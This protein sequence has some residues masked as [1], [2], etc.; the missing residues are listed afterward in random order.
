MMKKFTPILFFLLASTAFSQKGYDIKINIKN[1][2]DTVAYLG[3][4]YWDK[5]YLL[6]TCKK[7]RKGVIEFKGKDDLEKGMYLLISQ[8]KSK[9][10]DFFVNDASS[11]TMN[12]N[13]D[14]VE[15][16][17]KVEGSKDNQDF[18]EYKQYM[19]SKHMELDGFAKQTKGMSKSDSTKFMLEKYMKLDADVRKFETEFV[20]KHKGSFV[21]D[22][23]NLQKEKTLTD[24]PKASNGR[25]DSA[26]QYT[27]YK[28]H[29]WDG[30]NFD[31]ERLLR[32]PFFYERHKRYFD[33]VILPDPD[34]ICVEVDKIISKT[35]QDGAMNQF[36]I[37]KY[38]YDYETSK[39]IGF[40][41]VFVHM[42][43]TYIRTGKAK[44]VYDESVTKKIL[45]R[46]DILK[47]LLIGSKSPDLMVID[48]I[49][50]KTIHK[51]GF[52]T[53][54]TS[55][56]LSKLYAKHAQQLQPMFTTLYGVKAKYTVLIFWDVDC[57]HCQTVIPKLL[58]TYH[59][60][61]K[62][63]DIKVMS[64]YT[65]FDFEKW[66]KYVIDKKLDFINVY[67]PIHLNNVREKFDINS[68]PKIFILDKDKIIKGR[69]FDESEIPGFITRLEEME[70][71]AKK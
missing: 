3:R 56:S 39:Y 65:Q 33:N 60:L 51:M 29:F 15:R 8:G 48:T 18:A 37:G 71:A 69:G 25:P 40:D 2:P 47:P 26:Y 10:F 57:S 62:K 9:Y 44:K 4:Y 53:A 46:G 27:Y 19:I 16:F 63:Y 66:R 61:R 38:T 11:F 68:T 45:E 1:A 52:D 7:V 49:N 6:D 23:L 59:E 41:K 13:A 35:T 64:V 43:D 28:T 32:T 58:E 14:D 34:T 31:D 17:M 42:I 21:A 30:V 55:E 70:K 5:P 54:K 50:G 24:I 67:D 36:F 12:T 22:V 20:E